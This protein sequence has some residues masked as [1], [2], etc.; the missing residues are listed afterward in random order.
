MHQLRNYDAIFKKER[1][2]RNGSL[3]AL[4]CNRHNFMHKTY[5]VFTEE[6]HGGDVREIFQKKF[7]SSFFLLYFFFA[8]IA[9][10]L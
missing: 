7:P 6:N 10:Y 4:E 2:K 3:C 5:V 9:F 1:E 8:F